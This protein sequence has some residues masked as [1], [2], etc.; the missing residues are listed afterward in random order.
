MLKLLIRL[1]TKLTEFIFLARYA[2]NDDKAEEVNHLLDAQGNDII[3]K[4]SDEERKL[5]FTK[6]NSNA[7]ALELVKLLSSKGVYFIT[8]D[9]DKLVEDKAPIFKGAYFTLVRNLLMLQGEVKSFFDPMDW[10]DRGKI[11]KFFGFIDFNRELDEELVEAEYDMHH[12][13]HN[14]LMLSRKFNEE[15][16][17][18]VNV[19]NSSRSMVEAFE[20][21]LKGDNPVLIDRVI[22][23]KGGKYFKYTLNNSNKAVYVP[24]EQN[25]IIIVN[26]NILIRRNY[27]VGN[28]VVDILSDLL[29]RSIRTTQRLVS[30]YKLPKEFYVDRIQ[31]TIFSVLY[32]QQTIRGNKYNP[33]TLISYRQNEVSEINK[34]IELHKLYFAENTKELE[35]DKINTRK[36]LKQRGIYAYRNFPLRNRWTSA[37][38]SDYVTTK[39]NNIV[40]K[41]VKDDN[42]SLMSYLTGKS[43]ARA[44]TNDGRTAMGTRHISESLRLYDVNGDPVP[45]DKRTED[46]IVPLPFDNVDIHRGYGIYTVDFKFEDSS[47]LIAHEGARLLNKS[48]IKLGYHTGIKLDTGFGDK[49]IAA[50]LDDELYTITKDG[51][52]IDLSILVHDDAPGRDNPSSVISGLAAGVK[53]LGKNVLEVFTVRDGKEVSLGRHAIH[54]TYFYVTDHVRGSLA[55]YGETILMDEYVRK[56]SI[57]RVKVGQEMITK[58]AQLEMYYTIGNLFGGV[59]KLRR[60]LTK[61]GWMFKNKAKTLEGQSKFGKWGLVTQMMQPKITGYHA[62]AIP[63]RLVP[64]DEM[65]LHVNEEDAEIVFKAFKVPRHLRMSILS[66]SKVKHFVAE[67]LGI[68]HPMIRISNMIYKKLRIIVVD[69]EGYKFPYYHVNPIT[70]ALMDGDFD[71]DEVFFYKV[72]CDEAIKEIKANLHARFSI[73]DYKVGHYN[74]EFREITNVHDYFRYLEEVKGKS[75]TGDPFA[76]KPMSETIKGAAPIHLTTVLSKALIGRSKG[77]IMKLESHLTAFIY[78]NHLQS[79]Y[80][81]RLAGIIQKLNET[82]TQPTISMQKWTDNLA[83]AIKLHFKIAHLGRIISAAVDGLLANTKGHIHVN[84]YFTDDVKTFNTMKNFDRVIARADKDKL[85]KYNEI[86]TDLDYSLIN[87]LRFNFDDAGGHYSLENDYKRIIAT[88]EEFLDKL[89]NYLENKLESDINDLTDLEIFDPEFY[90]YKEEKKAGN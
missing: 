11:L 43:L 25:G 34:I 26:G 36:N 87:Y 38:Y 13:I 29:N 54:W 15:R 37:A 61:V 78:R 12:E 83:D 66:R 77:P 50:F 35:P 22:S 60:T 30:A 24:V 69:D 76:L 44:N 52:R 31:N 56:D 86:F 7:E 67:G 63:N 55:D 3:S 20:N 5:L 74:K 45:F 64:I 21:G 49:G 32:R 19:F 80:G 51:K 1:V 85:A 89:F 6:V 17:D 65:H 10:E 33:Y 46:D 4:M 57:D 59:M 58:L 27:L 79:T 18:F 42:V 81:R 40:R 73:K 47:G 53:K 75:F 84:T 28:K 71:G 72:T 48:L 9:T 39:G 90:F 88:P 16:F 14:S 23:D 82:Y 8:T 62:T 2:M 70:H 41:F 68:R